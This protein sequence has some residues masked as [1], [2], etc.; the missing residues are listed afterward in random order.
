MLYQQKKNSDEE[1]LMLETIE[2]SW[3]EE[4]ERLTKM[5][6]HIVSNILQQNYKYIYFLVVGFVSKDIL[7]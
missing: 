5:L 2:E 6:E 3:C 7:P 1:M 4:D